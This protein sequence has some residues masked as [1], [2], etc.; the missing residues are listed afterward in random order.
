MSPHFTVHW[1]GGTTVTCAW[2]PTRGYDAVAFLAH[3]GRAALIDSVNDPQSLWL[4]ARWCTE[5]ADLGDA[6][7][8]GETLVC[9]LSGQD[10][11]DAAGGSLGE[12]ATLI[13]NLRKVRP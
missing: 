3:G 7:T 8:L 4:A 2:S 13:E 1:P 12:I 10:P 5:I 11:H 9:M 6:D